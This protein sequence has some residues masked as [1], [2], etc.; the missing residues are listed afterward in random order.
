ME[1]DMDKIS[2]APVQIWHTNQEVVQVFFFFVS[3]APE[4]VLFSL[5]EVA[6]N[7]LKSMDKNKDKIEP[8]F[9]SIKI[10]DL[11]FFLRVLE[12]FEPWYKEAKTND[13][14]TLI[15]IFIFFALS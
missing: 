6:L 14:R 8:S 1:F 2:M 3:F 7:S 11:I 12:L 9:L 4:F 10:R 5:Q 13:R 15:F